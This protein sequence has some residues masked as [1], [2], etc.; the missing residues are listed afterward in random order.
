MESTR[1][2]LNLSI[3]TKFL[4]L[5]YLAQFTTNPRCKSLIV[6]IGFILDSSPRYSFNDE[7]SF[8]KNL[9]KK[10]GLSKNGVHAA[11]T[12]FSSSANLRIKFS[13]ISNF[14][15]AVNSIAVEVGTARIDLALQNAK[16][17][18]FLEKNG[19]RPS[20]EKLL[21]FLTDGSQT[22]TT[23]AKV[24]AQGIRDMGINVVVIGVGSEV[25]AAKLAEL[26]GGVNSYIAESFAELKSEIFV[27]KIAR[28]GCDIGN[29]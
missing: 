17:E 27:Q 18:M 8:L 20:V 12:T 6:D 15:S 7:K 14:E 24:L 5:K 16:D 19:G 25:N 2:I 28:A 1:A 9:V 21:I 4:F 22:E 11:V 29:Y 13:E 3:A 26:S 10:L 23:G